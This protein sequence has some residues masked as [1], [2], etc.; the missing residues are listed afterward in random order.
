MNFTI[1]YMALL[2]SGAYF[3][4]MVVMYLLVLLARHKNEK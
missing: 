1:F 3:L 2:V 4:G